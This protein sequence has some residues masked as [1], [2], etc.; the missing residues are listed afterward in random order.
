MRKAH[1]RQSCDKSA[2]FEHQPARLPP[3]ARAS[4]AL[5]RQARQSA[6]KHGLPLGQPGEW[7]SVRA[8][9]THL[10]PIRDNTVKRQF[11]GLVA[12]LMLT[13]AAAGVW[14]WQDRPLTVAVTPARS[15]VATDLVY[16][17]GYVEALQPVAI[18]SRLTAPVMRVLVAEGDR[19]RAGQPLVI[20]ADDEQRGL[21]DQAAAQ[22]RSAGQVEARTLALFSQGWVTRAARDKAVA[23]ADAARAGRATASARLDQLV[24]R[25]SADGIVT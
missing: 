10:A 8:C 4:A 3:S 11:V 24:V 19:V 21:L 13:G 9:Q 6:A 16:A 15:G 7:P 20:L 5:L 17:T 2:I 18:A 22:S 23:D 25:A 14:V 1:R 12:G